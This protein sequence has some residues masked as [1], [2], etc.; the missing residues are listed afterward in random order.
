MAGAVA[1]IFREIFGFDVNIGD[2]VTRPFAAFVI[3]LPEHRNTGLRDHIHQ[4]FAMAGDLAIVICMIHDR[5]N[6]RHRNRCCRPAGP[7]ILKRQHPRNFLGKFRCRA[8]IAI[9]LHTLRP[10]GFPDHQ[11]HQSRLAV[12][13]DLHHLMGVIADRLEWHR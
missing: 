3:F 4:A 8:G 11:E 2:A 6:A 13:R 10:C 9:G 1:A 7:H 12:A 5:K